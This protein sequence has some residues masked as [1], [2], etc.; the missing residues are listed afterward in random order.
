MD[1]L[2]ILKVLIFTIFS[3]FVQGDILCGYQTC[4]DADYCCNDQCCDDYNSVYQL[5][6]FWFIWMVGFL[7]IVS[8]VIC[9]RRRRAARM[10]YIRIAEVQPT[11]YSSV[12]VANQY[13]HVQPPQYYQQPTA[14][15][16]Y[17]PEYQQSNIPKQPPPPYQ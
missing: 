10:R 2:N 6:W 13:T 14:P 12:T 3:Q 17:P 15:Q 16:Q 7:L 9:I 4:Y 11:G 5:W 8:C 1:G